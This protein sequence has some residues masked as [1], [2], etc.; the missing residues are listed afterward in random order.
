MKNYLKFWGT[1]GSCSVSGPE[2]AHFGGNSCCLEVRY[3]KTLIILDAGTGIRPLGLTLKDQNIDL[4]LSHTHWDHLI[5]FPFFEPIY[6]KGHQIKI[7]APKGHGRSCKELFHQLLA[8]EFFPVHLN[9]MQAQLEFKTI[10]E[11]TPVQIGPLILDFHHTHHPGVAY[12]FKIKT[13]HQTIG[14]VTDNEVHLETQRSFVQ[15]FKG[16]DCLIHE[17]QY[18]PEEYEHK[19][20]WGHSS[21]TRAID[22]I[23]QLQ[24]GQWLVSH[25][26]PKH[27]DA[28]LRALEKQARSHKLPCSVEWIPDGYVLPL[29]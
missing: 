28:D 6:H 12:G 4:F 11:N 23:K 26:D 14:Y 16:C 29:K 1:R 27:S 7:W 19:T 18:T 25:H 9:E 15:F 22:L 10:E 13:P 17:A 3:E 21:L 5:G 24:P 20:G 2:Y 8:T